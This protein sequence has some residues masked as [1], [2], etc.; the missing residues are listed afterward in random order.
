MDKKDENEKE[1]RRKESITL[2]TTMNLDVSNTVNQQNE[3]SNPQQLEENFD[4]LLKGNVML[5]VDAALYLIDSERK[6]TWPAANKASSC[7][8]SHLER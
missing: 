7:N 6:S 2:E 4:I 1:Q 8:E 3:I 5:F